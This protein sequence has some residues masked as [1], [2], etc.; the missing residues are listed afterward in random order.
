ML[1]GAVTAGAM[2]TRRSMALEERPRVKGMKAGGLLPVEV[3]QAGVAWLMIWRIVGG[4]RSM[5]VW[6]HVMMDQQHNKE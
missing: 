5:R 1:V 4:L 3:G 2:G 6:S